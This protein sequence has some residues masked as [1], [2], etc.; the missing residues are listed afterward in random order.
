MSPVIDLAADSDVDLHRGR[1][2]HTDVHQSG[3][4]SRRAGHPALA[5]RF[6]KRGA[7]DDVDMAEGANS[8]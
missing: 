5:D 3:L 7:H 4:D 1:H 8:R 6:G 2:H